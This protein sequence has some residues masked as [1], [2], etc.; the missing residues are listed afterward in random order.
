M[1]RT[2]ANAFEG[3]TVELNQ[4]LEEE[5]GVRALLGLSLIPVLVKR[6][7]TEDIIENEAITIELR[8]LAEELGV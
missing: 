4:P 8:S 7:L 5:G 2:A 1:V 3:M 6:E